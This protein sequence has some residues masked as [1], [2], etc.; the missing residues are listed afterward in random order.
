MGA[1][2]FS[3]A[4]VARACLSILLCACTWL[5]SLPAGATSVSIPKADIRLTKSVGDVTRLGENRFSVPVL[6]KLHNVGDLRVDDISIV[7]HI[8]A[9]ITPARVVAITHLRSEGDFTHVNAEFDGIMNTQL[10]GDHQ[11]LKAGTFGK[12]KFTLE[13]DS[14]GAPGPFFNQAYVSARDKTN[15]ENVDACSR[16]DTYSSAK[17]ACVPTE[18][19][20]PSAPAV[21]VGLAKAASPVIVGADGRL[22]TE[23]TF[24]LRNYGEMDVSG[25]QITD[26][27][28]GVFG[29]TPFDVLSL[30]SPS[31]MANPAFDGVGDQRILS[32]G[33]SLPVGS[34]A[35]ASMVVAF[36]PEGLPGTEGVFFNSALVSTGDGAT[37]VSSN[38][39][40]PDPDGNYLPDESSPTPIPYLIPHAKVARLGIAKSATQA[41]QQSDGS[42]QSVFTLFIENLGTAEATGVNIYDDLSTTFADV[43]SFSVEPGSLLSDSL[44]INPDFDGVN[45]THL[46]SGADTLAAG[47]QARL[48]FAVNFVPALETGPLTNVAQIVGDGLPP[49]VS[50]PGDDPDPNGD[51][52]P[53]EEAPTEVPYVM[54]QPP[55]LLGLANAAGEVVQVD[56]ERFSV[57][58][59]VTLENLG[60]TTLTGV[61]ANND[62][63]T[64]FGQVPY[65]VVAANSSD[66]T[67]NPDFDGSVDQRLL[68]GVDTIEPDTSG[69]ITL[70][71]V[72]APTDN[73][74]TFFNSVLGTSTNSEDT[75]TN[76]RE[77]DP[78]GDGVPEEQT[79]TPIPY[80]R[81]PPEP[82]RLGLAKAATAATF[83]EGEL[84]TRF[85]FTLENFGAVAA[86]G[87]NIVDDLAS[88]FATASSYRVVAGSLQS[89]EFSVNPAFDGDGDTRL[90][91]GVDSLA[92]GGV[93]QVVVNVRF[94]VDADTGP[95][96]NVA[97]IVGD[98]LPPD[99]SVPGD[100]PD[101]NE[102]GDPDEEDPT[103]VPYD[104]SG[105][106]PPLIGLAKTA[107][108]ARPY[109]EG[110]FVTELTFFVENLGDQA[111][112]DLRLLDDLNSTFPPPATYVV[113]RETLV[114]DDLTVNAAFDGDRD[115][116]LLSS[117]NTLAAAASASVRLSVVFELNGETGPFLNSA[118]VT[119]AEGV[120]DRSTSGA[121]VDPNG[122]GMP[123]EDDPTLIEV[124][125]DPVI[126]LSKSVSDVSIS[127]QGYRV[128]FLLNIAN[129]GDV[130]LSNV[131]IT[132]ALRD[133]FPSPVQVEVVDPP[134][135]SGALSQSSTGFSLDQINL[136][137]GDESLQPEEQAS[138]T[139]TVDLVLGDVQ[140]PFTNQALGSGF[141]PDGRQVSDL[142]NAGVSPDPDVHTPTPVELPG[143][144]TG[145]VFLDENHDRALSTSDARLPTWRI[146]LL[147]A[148]GS[149]IQAISSDDDGRYLLTDISPASY[150][151]QFR[152]PDTEVVWG[153]E[154]VIVEASGLVV[155]DLPVDPQGVIYD[156]KARVL[157][158][159]VRVGLNDANGNPL[160]ESCLLPD[161]Q[162]QPVGQ[163]AAYRFVILHGNDSACPSSPSVYQLTINEVP[164]NFVDGFSTRIPAEPSDY[165]LV[166][167]SEPCLVQLQN[168]APAVN[169]DST[170]HATYRASSST[171]VLINNHL[172][173][174]RIVLAGPRNAFLDIDVRPSRRTVQ[175]GGVVGYTITVTN[176]SNVP[177][178]SV[179]VVD[180]T[181]PGL[182]ALPD[183]AVL[184]R[185]GGDDI[186][187][188]ADDLRTPLIATGAGPVEFDPF[189]L[190]PGEQAQILFV[191][192]VSAGARP[193]PLENTS[194]ASE[195]FVGS[196][197]TVQDRST[198][199][200]IADPLMDNATVLGK[201]F[202]DHNENGI[203]DPD[204]VPVERGLAGVRLIT[205]EG[206]L[207]ETDRY[208][209]FHIAD[210]SVTREAGINYVVKIDANSL[211]S[212]AQ[213]MSDTRQ[214]VRLVPGDI[215]KVNFAVRHDE[216]GEDC[217]GEYAKDY[218]IDPYRNDKKLDVTVQE[219]LESQMRLAENRLVNFRVTSN[220]FVQ[221]PNL[222]LVVRALESDR[223]SKFEVAQCVELLSPYKF[224]PLSLPARARYEYTLRAYADAVCDSDQ[225]VN[226]K[227]LM[228]FVSEFD[229]TSPQILD[230]RFHD[231]G[232]GFGIRP[233][234]RSLL[235]LDQ[236]HIRQAQ[237]DLRVHT[238]PVDKV[239]R[240]ALVASDEELNNALEPKWTVDPNNQVGVKEI[241]DSA[242]EVNFNWQ[243]VQ[244]TLLSEAIPPIDAFTHEVELDRQETFRFLFRDLSPDEIELTL[245]SNKI[246]QGDLYKF[247]IAIPS[248]QNSPYYYEIG[249]Y[250][251]EFSNKQYL[252]VFCVSASETGTK[253][254]AFPKVDLSGLTEGL[255]I[256]V[257]LFER[258][259]CTAIPGT[260]VYRDSL[261]LP[262]SQTFH[263]DGTTTYMTCCDLPTS[264]RTFIDDANGVTTIR[265]SNNSKK[266]INAT[267]ACILQSGEDDP[268]ACRK[269]RLSLDAETSAEIYVGDF[270]NGPNSLDTWRRLRVRVQALPNI[271]FHYDVKRFRPEEEGHVRPPHITAQC[272]EIGAIPQVTEDRG[273]AAITHP[274]AIYPDS[275][276]K[277]TLLPA[278]NYGVGV[279][280]FTIGGYSNS[281]GLDGLVALNGLDDSS[282]V[283]GRIAGYWRGSKPTDQADIKWVVQLD[284]TKD[285]LSNLGDNLKR[286]NPRRLFRQLD[287]DLYYPTY[288]D[289]S[290]TILDTNSQGAFYGRVEY[291]D[292]QA[293]WG[294]YNTGLTDTEFSHYNR[295]LYGASAEFAAGEIVRPGERR[296]QMKVF[297]SEAQSVLAH[298]EFRATG[299]SLYYLRHT[300]IVMGSEK[301]MIEVRRRDSEQIEERQILVAG[302][303]YEIDPIQ[304]RILLQRPL[305]QVMRERHNTIIQSRSLDGDEV[306]LVADY[307]Y[308]PASFAAED[309]V[310]GVR[311]QTWLGS[312]LSLGV[313]HITEE[314]GSGDYTM[315]GLDTV[316]HFGQRSYLSAEYAHSDEAHLGAD[317][318]SYDGGLTF[319]ANG[320]A[321][322]ASDRSGRALGFEGYLDL[323]DAGMSD[324]LFKVW[325]KERAS[326]YSSGRFALGPAVKDQGVELQSKLSDH[327]VV[328][329]SASELERAGVERTRAA[330]VQLSGKTCAPS[331]DG[332]CTFLDIEGRHESTVSQSTGDSPWRPYVGEANLLGIRL[333]QDISADTTVYGSLQTALETKDDYVDNDR[334][335][336]GVNTRVNDRFAVSLEASDGDRGEALVGGVDFTLDQRSSVN[337]S[338]GVGSGAL[339]QFATKYQ[340]TEG[341][342][343]YGSY[344]VDPD[345]SDTERNMLTFGQRRDLGNRTRIFTES[346]FGKDPR[347]AS[348]GH[349]FGLEYDAAQDWVLSSTVQHS[350]VDRDSGDV[351]RTAVSMG[352]SFQNSLTRFSARIEVRE[353][354]GAGTD[355]RQY[356][357]STAL[358]RQIDESSRL[359][360]KLNIAWLEDDES[361]RELGRFVEF[362]LGYAYR[363]VHADRFNMIS[364]YA[365]LTDVGSQG[366]TDSAGDERSHT[367]ATE[368]LYDVSHDFQL[369]GK[370][371]WRVG[372]SR[373]DKG[374]G[375]WFDQRTG[376]AIA[377]ALYRFQL[378]EEDSQ[379][380]FFPNQ[381]ELVV[382]YRWLRDFEGEST[383]RGALVG[384]Y[385]QI[386]GRTLNLEKILAPTIRVGVGYNF[387]GFD[388][389]MRRDSYKSH[390]WFVDLM[391]VF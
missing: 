347:Q 382:E 319:D 19:R 372:E 145:T 285:D 375:D 203:Q 140:G 281:G 83:T 260:R 325:W 348:T 23:F 50:T 215:G 219:V 286:E 321:S 117:G 295:S 148:N 129:V 77:T 176:L 143:G 202:V 314:Q 290:T 309:Y 24:T 103:E 318:S 27:L 21:L 301:L 313:T 4:A 322:L 371:A 338:S 263:A 144:V 39:E 127:D 221:V 373:L 101:P 106:S 226:E 7:D 252:D 376:L 377:R 159:N 47:V 236:I 209:R 146:E 172:P 232:L 171:Q 200:L 370:L 100:D 240:E 118:L 156:S 199:T 305:S 264:L 173:I 61:Q 157:V 177:A 267:V 337:V 109:S 218:I 297:G 339:T 187:E 258:P 385:K 72:F 160:P 38:G 245:K 91:L 134:E 256:H 387:S 262:N 268:S 194:V 197:E 166:S 210:I 390:G 356:I 302:R 60:V 298:A 115:S 306:Y 45:E 108:A 6:I 212:G 349:V 364:R 46:L 196:I 273:V 271:N 201:V 216:V 121:N 272:Y 81:V 3:A 53:D 34:S 334:V 41:V 206:L 333:G 360:S 59:T 185:P 78:N 248:K 330:R 122:D 190:E 84:E 163:D 165:D 104:P 368:G 332:G 228:T 380:L 133:A 10:L 132:D 204:H 255:E 43:V 152:H 340:L 352:A 250:H 351:E 239:L 315:D 391:A 170:Y 142:S 182:Q 357:A 259:D 279:L 181:A 208:G 113:L 20:L 207:I 17:Q 25:L 80:L 67:I 138:V 1:L 54:P 105:E 223:P 378:P 116:N 253:N 112:S 328:S 124:V 15:D 37:D 186:F 299:G 213:V 155:V 12:I 329:G 114:S 147:D 68:T 135:V 164:E 93:G 247:D 179:D 71:V 167:C 350:L 283:D 73:E 335:A 289:D 49:D 14:V 355:L 233:Q 120:Q 48:Q 257:K 70:S 76:G 300:D 168:D 131:Q 137:S 287:A 312:H 128:S 292:T 389:D 225:T 234:G 246:D 65:T 365:Y 180:Q 22:V 369:G 278:V 56:N 130:E 241:K 141:A 345:R 269:Q 11:Y 343:L 139:F 88:A 227:Q 62:L 331:S 97:Q 89:G 98:G 374:V 161:Q 188:T 87:V 310:Y 183:T 326:G 51:G 231:E 320:L 224:V 367:L 153:R 58:L 303:D 18:I 111:L 9:E 125:S 123:D 44:T 205:P 307:E 63:A 366:Q 79:P 31:L 151:V 353:D 217:C 249:L 198:V 184:L 30:S 90:L 220:Y 344:R 280:D 379:E 192:R 52:D 75:S 29:S 119:T 191:A 102:D 251:A 342:E 66:F 126:A 324:G 277:R 361:T 242:L 362:D 35:T 254:L 74:G 94:K 341:H 99:V 189:E 358:T 346:Q 42:L 211:P 82:A 276:S 193:G 169:T 85:T 57:M 304:G 363:P 238:R 243:G 175:V 136:L 28:A 26:D 386:D 265:L 55:Y 274:E 149:F 40:N 383:R 316:F 178:S 388:D 270:V 154:E 195:D 13:F 381:L 235:S 323:Q 150:F 294:N 64:T 214:I 229:E 158:P 282:Y 336:A 69:T 308:V 237:R 162:N 261:T 110:G 266:S 284:S 291:G 32:G 86:T 92:P 8:A 354:E 2:R 275:E 230:L 107:S 288:G 174:D 222:V 293:Q 16:T 244:K 384:L 96:T 327:W 311:A 95:L 317:V 36:T 33:D 359:L 5:A 296:Y